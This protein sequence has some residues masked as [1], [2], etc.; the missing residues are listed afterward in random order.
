MSISATTSPAER[1]GYSAT[2]VD[3]AIR[4]HQHQDSAR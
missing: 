3:T 1:L 2:D 4:S